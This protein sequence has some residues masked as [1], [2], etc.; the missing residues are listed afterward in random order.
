[1][2][3]CRGSLRPRVS[4]GATS[5]YSVRNRRAPRSIPVTDMHS[6]RGRR[7]ARLAGLASLGSWAVKTAPGFWSEYSRSRRRPILPAPFTPS[8]RVWSDRGLHAAWLGHS[9]V[10]LKIDGVTILTDPVFSARV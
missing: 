5:Q 2:A 10:L 1:M 6:H 7:R 9:T 3:V 4:P 8:P